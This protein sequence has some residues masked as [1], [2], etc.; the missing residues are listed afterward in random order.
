LS[1]SHYFARNFFASAITIGSGGAAGREGPTAQIAAGIGSIVGTQ[2][3]L[4]DD[5]RRYLVIVG[6]AAGLSAIFKSP[7]GTAIFSVE[8]LYA[9]MAFESEVLIFSL[10]AASVAYAGSSGFSSPSCWA[11]VTGTCSSR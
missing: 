10:I 9:A 5:E 8:I 7:L 4:S 3:G 6:M 2:L 11:G 1:H